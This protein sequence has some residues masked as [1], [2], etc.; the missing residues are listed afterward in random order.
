[1]QV[2]RRLKTWWPQAPFTPRG[3]I[4]FVFALLL[5]ALTTVAIAAVI[6]F[7]DLGHVG[8]I[9][10]IPVL[11][12]AM[13]WGLLPALFAATMSV[14]ASAFF[15]YP[16]IYSFLVH[17]WDQLVD[18]ILFTIVAVVTSQLA[19]SLKRHADIAD[20]AVS[21][22]RIRA[23][24]DQ[25]REALIGSVSHELRT[26]LASIVGSTYILAN[27]PGVK[28]DARLA[29]LADD[30]RHEAERLND[31][32]QN[33]LDASRITSAGIRSHLQ[34]TDVADIVNATIERQHRRLSAHKLTLDVPDELALVHVDPVLIEQAVGQVLDNAVKYS[35]AGSLIHVAVAGYDR[36]IS[37][38]I[39]D[40]GAGLTAEEANQI[41]ERFYRSPRQ[42]A[43][44]GSG[45][46]LWIARAFVLACGGTIEAASEGPGHGTTVTIRL[47][48]PRP[49]LSEESENFDE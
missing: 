39:A 12:A 19:I 13:R 24:T 17:N 37:V 22:A 47:P 7:V 29:A 27:A 14:A 32:I 15:F 25:L 16:P 43:T 8:T 42:H 10:L 28:D 41:W 26:P 5:V 46:G 20:R 2:M 23:E 9:Y 4:G 31:D 49:T 36:E 21:E 34:W 38:T 48:A 1:M 6:Q 33:L 30:V 40:Q 35:S 44:T 45:L 11:I 3:V 18:L